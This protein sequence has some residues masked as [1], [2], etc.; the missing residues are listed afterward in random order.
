MLQHNTTD[1]TASP[2]ST[3]LYHK[4]GRTFKIRTKEAQLLRITW[5]S[6]TVHSKTMKKRKYFNIAIDN[7]NRETRA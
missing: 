2:S 4:Q 6:D 1:R 5:K 7:K 3:N